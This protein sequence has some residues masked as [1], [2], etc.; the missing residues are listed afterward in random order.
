MKRQPNSSTHYR[1]SSRFGGKSFGVQKRVVF[2]YPKPN[3]KTKL[4]EINWHSGSIFLLTPMCYSYMKYGIEYVPPIDVQRPEWE[5]H[6][7]QKHVMESAYPTIDLHNLFP[8]WFFVTLWITQKPGGQWFFDSV[9]D[10]FSVP[11]PPPP[12][13]WD[14]WGRRDFEIGAR[15]N[16]G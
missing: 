11:P 2:V 3:E 6:L 16:F 15:N 12:I 9:A 14:H 4:Y 10:L 5:T 8:K 1:I 13:T 7:S